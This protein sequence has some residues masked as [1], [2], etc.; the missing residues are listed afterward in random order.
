MMTNFLLKTLR[1]NF[2]FGK[3]LDIG[4]NLYILYIVSYALGLENFLKFTTA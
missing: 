4:K 1:I 3:L 2:R